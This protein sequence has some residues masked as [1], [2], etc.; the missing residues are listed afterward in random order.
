MNA[1]ITIDKA[2]RIVLPKQIRE[3]LQLSPG[4]AI[5]LEASNE[6]VVLRPARGKGR[7]RKEQG[8][9][10]FDSGQ[11]LS[12]ETVNKTIRGI[13]NEREHRFLGKSR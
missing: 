5:E 12:V 11:P 2:G 6:Q 7:M 3:E 9:W 4:D 10:V 8:V 1:T 13:R